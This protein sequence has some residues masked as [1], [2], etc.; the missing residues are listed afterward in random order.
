MRTFKGLLK[1]LL[2]RFQIELFRVPNLYRPKEPLSVPYSTFS[3]QSV[4]VVVVVVA[5]GFPW[6]PKREGR[7]VAFWL[8]L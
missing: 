8:A 1:N 4:N 2:Q 5:Y 6:A 3:F 7:A